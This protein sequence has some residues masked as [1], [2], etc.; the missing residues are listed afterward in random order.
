M[1]QVTSAVII[2]ALLAGCG[3]TAHIEKSWRD[4][5]V[6]VDMSKLNKVLVV[7]LLK[8]ETNRHTD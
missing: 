3:P 6:T 1:K 4:P 7:A 8:D 5:E 2:T